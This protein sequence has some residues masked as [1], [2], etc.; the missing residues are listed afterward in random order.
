MHTQVMNVLLG[1]GHHFT[2]YTILNHYIVHLKYTQFFFC[3]FAISWATLMAFGGSQA[4]GQI[5]A[6]GTGL[7]HSHSNSGSKPHLQPTPQV[8]AMPDP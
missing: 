8:I 6:V 2:M 5:R 1:W 3:L 7:R 4:R